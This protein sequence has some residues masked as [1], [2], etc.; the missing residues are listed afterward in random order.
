MRY[1]LVSRSR[2]V[3][4]FVGVRNGRCAIGRPAGVRIAGAGGTNHQRFIHDRT[5]GN[6]RAVSR[7]A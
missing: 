3:L 6:I 4:V 7:L 1:H 2:Q 5:I